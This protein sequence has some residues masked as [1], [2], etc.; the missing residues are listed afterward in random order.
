MDGIDLCKF[1]NLEEILSKYQCITKIVSIS[2]KMTGGIH[3]GSNDSNTG[4]HNNHHRQIDSTIVSGLRWLLGWIEDQWPLLNLRVE[5]ESQQ[6]I[7]KENDTMQQRINRIQQRILI[8]T[9]SKVPKIIANETKRMSNIIDHQPKSINKEDNEIISSNVEII[10]NENLGQQKEILSI[11]NEAND[12]TT[13]II[14]D[15]SS[16]T[17]TMSPSFESKSPTDS[18]QSIRP[19]LKRTNK[20]YPTIG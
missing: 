16:Q 19:P 9:E 15:E 7:S 17:R 10:D 3:N 6:Q 2:A 8:E 4:H 11:P 20:I 18:T 1:T 14:N 12:Q 13:D 5:Q